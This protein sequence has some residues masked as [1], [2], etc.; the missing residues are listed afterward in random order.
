MYIPLK[1]GDFPGHPENAYRV[2][3]R[4][5]YFEML[6]FNAAPSQLLFDISKAKYHLYIIICLESFPTI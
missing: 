6:K 1:K 4:W 5:N 2:E 3:M